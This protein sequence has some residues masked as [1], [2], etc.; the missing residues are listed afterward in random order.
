MA[1][2]ELMEQILGQQSKTSRTFIAF[3]VVTRL[4]PILVLSPLGGMV[5]DAYDRK[6]SMIILDIIAAILPLLFIFA[7]LLKSTSM[8]YGIL[9]LQGSVQALYEPCRSAILPLMVPDQEMQKK[10]TTL[11]GLVW[12]SMGAF[13]SGIG[14]YMVAVLGTQGCFGEERLFILTI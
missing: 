4:L 13:A 11:I 1:V 6:K 14:G 10:A 12:S 9:L 2:I 8:I 5:A 7:S 3:L